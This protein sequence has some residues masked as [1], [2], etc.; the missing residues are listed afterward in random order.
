VFTLYTHTL[1][2][3][4]IIGQVLLNVVYRL[5]TITKHALWETGW[6]LRNWKL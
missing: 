1:K 6:E 4:E 5:C 3:L 2:L